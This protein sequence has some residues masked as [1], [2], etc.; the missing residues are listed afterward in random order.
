MKKNA[1]YQ[2]V[3]V[4]GISCRFPQANTPEE[5]WQLLFEGKSVIDKIP[6]DRWNIQDYYDP[7]PNAPGKTNQNMGAF[8]ENIHHFDPY[9][10][11]VSPKEAIEM[12]PSQKVMMELAWELYES[13]SLKKEQFYGSKTGVYIG[14]IWA[15]FE[16]LRKMRKTEINNFSAIGQ[17]SN[18]IANRISYH[19]GLTGPSLVIDTGCSSSLVAL[20][21]SI[22]SLRDHSSDLC[23]AGG[24]NHMLDPEEYVYLAKFGGLSSKGKCSA[25][26]AE[27]DGFVRGEGAGAVLLKRLEDAERDGDKIYAVIRGGAITNNGFNVNMPATS[28]EGQIDVLAQAYCDA[29][30]SP[31]DVD[32]VEA[33]GTGTRLGDPV[34]TSALGE[35][36]A[37]ERK[38]DTPLLVGSVKTNLGHCESSSGIAGV[39]KTILAF[40]HRT[41]PKN[42]NF[43]T[44]N[45][46]IDFKG[47]NLK[48][49]TENIVCTNDTGK[50]LVAGVSSYGWGG[51]N[52]HVVLEE[53]RPKGQTDPAPNGEHGFLFLPLSARTPKA[54]QEYAAKYARFLKNAT[55]SS[56]LLDICA[57]T[58]VQKADF[59]YKKMFFGK[60]ADEITGQLND[61]QNLSSSQVKPQKTGENAKVVFVF[62]GQGAQWLG[63]G[64]ELYEKE[65][66]FKS[67]IDECETA[68]AK[69]VDWSLIDEI[70][71]AKEN[72]QL[73]RI[74]VIQPYLFAMQIALAR[75]WMAKGIMPASVAGHSMGEVAAAYTAGALSMDDA[76]NIIC[77]RSI[78]MNT[79]SGQ[80]GAM[81]VT[82][83][84]KQQA[85]ELVAKHHGKISLAVLNSPKSTVL[86]GDTQIIESI[87][88]DLTER[89]LFCRQV[90]VDVASHSPQ[91]DLIKDQ[92]YEKVQN[93]TPGKA[94]LAIYSTVRNQK[95]NGDEMDADYWR[96]NLR[97]T[98]LFS[99]V[100]QQLLA[101]GHHIFIE[102]SPHPVLGTAMHECAEHLQHSNVSIVASL[103]RD[104]P[105]SDEL[106]KNIGLAYESGYPI[107]WD[108]LYQ[109]SRIKHI[110]LPSYPLQKE[111][112][113]I[114]D[115]SAHFENGKSSSSAHPLIGNRIKLADADSYYWESKISLYN[116]PY[117][118]HHQVNGTAVFPGG[119]YIEM[120]HAATK[121]V[122]PQGQYVIQNLEFVQSVELTE[123]E[124]VQMQMKIDSL[125]GKLANF[126][127]FKQLDGDQWEMV[128]NGNLQQAQVQM[129]HRY[130]LPNSIPIKFDKTD[131]YN[132][133][134]K[135]GVTFRE[136]FQ[137]IEK[138]DIHEDVV[139][140]M[141]NLSENE[142]H[143][144]DQY[145][146]P[147]MLLDNCLHPL[148]GKAFAEVDDKTVKITFVQEI[149]QIKI[150]NITSDSQLYY[151]KTKLYPLQTDESRHTISVMGD[152]SVYDHDYKLV[153][154]LTGAHA[155]IIDTLTERT[156]TVDTS[157]MNI[158]D[159]VMDEHDDAKRKRIVENYLIDLV[160][161]AS[162]ASPDQLDTT[163]TFKNMGIDSLTTVQL[164]NLI[165]KQFKVKLSIK[166]FYQYPSIEGFANILV[167]LVKEQLSDASF[168]ENNPSNKWLSVQRPN[169][170]ASAILFLF[171]DAGGSIRLFENWGMFIDASIEM[172]TVQLPGR[173]DRTDEPLSN[174]L[175]DI[176]TELLPIMSKKIDKPF[177]VYGH[178]MGGLMAFEAVRRLQNEF[179]KQA[180]ELVVSGTPSLKGYV[181]HFVDRIFDQSYSDL[182][183]LSLITGPENN[184]FDPGNDA[185]KG[186]V[187]I[188]RSDFELIH[189]Y[190]YREMPKLNCRVT[191][192]HAQHDDRVN[193]D[194][195]KQW[196]AQTTGAFA[197]FLAEGGHN[198]VHTDAKA[199]AQIVNA[200]I[201]KYN[202]VE[203]Q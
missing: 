143:K 31:A 157:T 170:E 18:I 76:A 188:L 37:G 167:K 127:M 125:N 30:V 73:H 89:N 85:E 14:N 56:S 49:P 5:L 8:L 35:F 109:T 20:M 28:K 11:N 55:Q 138:F 4:I 133:F 99:S 181:N 17:S 66:A 129:S 22:Q 119:F 88:A 39:L 202:T 146:I 203:K 159:L 100:T 44:P 153:M 86:A 87:L 172:V 183:L 106:A 50:K 149:K 123:H 135:L 57:T 104:Y 158:L 65:P 93:I 34:E 79:L 63:M 145:T 46:E 137:N 107:D 59:E 150:G 16:H 166:L 51:T 70:N 38:S 194:D 101:D 10:F 69:Y 113:E 182:Q 82:E 117:L 83:L 54:L 147:P 164:R 118:A 151:T 162:K 200:S 116:L 36:F 177:F 74:N 61:L 23:I 92:L 60:N 190:R 112:Y 179:G 154:E 27:A 3:A 94:Y 196:Q 110:D 174:N 96:S 58:A 199:A 67:A 178:S 1:S 121:Q 84:D 195:V 141:I 98:V 24:V 114:K 6:S 156:E 41:F 102:V 72:S 173:D 32:F 97:N 62:P 77:T 193:L 171:H 192:I 144:P 43:N 152:I 132:S 80:G 131:I 103:H 155:K 75:L 180:R 47:W 9:F 15:D 111:N 91:M 124:A 115:L 81:A 186:L 64:K 168:T 40:R 139:Y 26:D 120:I 105:S 142:A 169:P 185:V 165:E 33:H 161:E 108:K 42:I 21:L 12:N 128:C 122:D 29:G 52:V 160:A 189:A 148:F 197:Y 7:D 25:F 163:M 187:K 184:Q 201:L 53:Y 19:F 126:K 2:A 68:F 95:L 71:A 176:L 130:A 78:L 48:V 175:D 191:A 13:S 140:A 134:R 136:T 45:P 198:F 90:K